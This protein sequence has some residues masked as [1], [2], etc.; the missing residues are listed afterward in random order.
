MHFNCI[1]TGQPA[2]Q[3]R[4][5]SE[6]MTFYFNQKCREDFRQDSRLKD[7]GGF[8]AT[9]ALTVVTLSSWLSVG[10]QTVMCLPSNEGQHCSSSS[11]SPVTSPPPLSSFYSAPPHL[12]SILPLS[13]AVSRIHRPS[14]HRHPTQLLLRCPRQLVKLHLGCLG[15]GNAHHHGD[16]LSC[17]L[18][19]G[20]VELADNI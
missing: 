8:C 11:S 10:S 18:H 17:A 15:N 13:P 4:Y 12:P 20:A 7:G 3:R 9:A 5:G 19:L 14:L 2:H 6:I 16:S 1:C